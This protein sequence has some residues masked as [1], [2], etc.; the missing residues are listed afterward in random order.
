MTERVPLEILEKAKDEVV[1]GA[2]GS[3]TDHSRHM[4]GLVFAKVIIF[5]LDLSLQFRHADHQ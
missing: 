3:K 1:P 5:S 2:L 4:F